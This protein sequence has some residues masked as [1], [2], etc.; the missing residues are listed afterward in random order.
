MAGIIGQTNGGF[1]IFDITDNAV[2]LSI[3]TSGQVGLGGVLSATEVLTVED[4]IGI[5]RSGVAAV[6]TLQMAGSG[7]IV[8]GHSG[9]HPLIIQANGTEVARFKNDGKVGI[10]IASPGAPLHVSSSIA[11]VVYFDSGHSNGPHVRFR[12]GGTDQFYIGGSGGIGGGSGYYDHYAISG[13]GIRF[14]TA[15]TQALVLDTSQNARFYGD[16]KVDGDITAETLIISSSVTNLTTQFAS[17][18]TRFGDTQDDLH[19]FTG[20]LMVSGARI[21]FTNGCS[22]KKII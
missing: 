16:V 15:A 4:T 8:N 2:R 12:K 17:G 22:S 5:K 18:S 9:Y 19:E 3:N 14:F 11:G 7:L 1:S 20:S 10:G 21:S 13:L 6:T